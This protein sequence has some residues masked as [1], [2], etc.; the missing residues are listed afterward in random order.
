MSKISIIIVIFT[1][2]TG[3]WNAIIEGLLF[4]KKKSS[5]EWARIQIQV[6]LLN[7]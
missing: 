6:V 3:A 5:I 1:V 4:P 7:L 2:V